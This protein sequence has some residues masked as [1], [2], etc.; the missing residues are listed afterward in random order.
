[1]KSNKKW[2][3]IHWLGGEVKMFG[4]EKEC[5]KWATT[6]SFNKDAPIFYAF[7]VA[8]VIIHAHKHTVISE[9]KVS[10]RKSRTY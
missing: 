2:C 7:P 6:N 8:G 4:S 10:G 1:M 5:K 3:V 9:E